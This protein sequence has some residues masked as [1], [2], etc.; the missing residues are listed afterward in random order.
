MNKPKPELNKTVT[1]H[2]GWASLYSAA[3]K[4]LGIPS[5]HRKDNLILND[6]LDLNELRRELY[7]LTQQNG[8]ELFPIACAQHVGPLTFGAFSTALW[9]ASNLN[10]ALQIIAEHSII[11]SSAIKLELHYDN[12]GNVEVWIMDYETLA[13][14]RVT[15]LGRTL[16]IATLVQ[17]VQSI[18]MNKTCEVQIKLTNQLGTESSLSMLQLMNNTLVEANHPLNKICIKKQN[19]WSNN[20][21]Y[22]TELHY[23]ALN[24]VRKQAETL[25]KMI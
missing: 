20:I 7:Y 12:L 25:K 5:T 9:T 17:I 4:Q 6:R 11:I 23:A 14:K 22:D 8:G 13:E 10:T 19:L 15:Y 1:L 2:K 3:Q 24:L 18:A 21:H 16:Y